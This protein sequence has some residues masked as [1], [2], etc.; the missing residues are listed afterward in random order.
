MV[1]QRIKRMQI[2]IKCNGKSWQY[3][4]GLREI[5]NRLSGILRSTVKVVESSGSKL[6][7][8]LS[9]TNP[10]AGSRYERQECIPCGQ[11]SA[12]GRLNNCKKRGVLYES[13]CKVCNPEGLNK[14][15]VLSDNREMPSIYVGETARSISERVKEH[16]L[17]FERQFEDSHILKHWQNH[18]Q[19]EGMPRFEFN[20]VQNR[21]TI[22]AK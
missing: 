12:G 2:L 19:G 16:W 4:K 18:H 22:G 15:G 7:H 11:G 1:W 21:D 20:I 14:N 5:L 9:N 13:H 6:Q 3:N 8:I 17:D 10:W